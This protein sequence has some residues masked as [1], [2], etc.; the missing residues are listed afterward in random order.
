MNNVINIKDKLGNER[1]LRAKDLSEI[2]VGTTQTT[3]DNWVKGGLLDRYKIGG[4]V[5]YKLSDVKKLIENSR[6][7]KRVG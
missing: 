4:G 5:Y 2:F 7:D 1:M 3:F 6:E